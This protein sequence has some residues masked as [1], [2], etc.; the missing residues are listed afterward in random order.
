MK[1]HAIIVYLHEISCNYSLF[2]FKKYL[3]K[4][5]VFHDIKT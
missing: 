3:I 2:T 5:L 1:S 4:Y